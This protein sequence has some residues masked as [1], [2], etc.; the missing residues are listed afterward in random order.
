MVS[1]V[2]R[3]VQRIKELQPYVASLGKFISGVALARDGLA[4]KN[5]ADYQRGLSGILGGAEELRKHFDALKEP[6]EKLRAGSTA[7]RSAALLVQATQIRAALV[8]YE[9]KPSDALIPAQGGDPDKPFPVGFAIAQRWVDVVSQI[10][11]GEWAEA[12]EREKWNEYAIA[13]FAFGPAGIVYV[14][15]KEMGVVPDVGAAIAALDKKLGISE[16]LEKQKEN[17]D[18]FWFGV[19]VAAG[20]TAGIA[21]L[22]GVGYLVRSFRG[23]DA[24]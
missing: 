3:A 12:I 13:V 14:L 21:G 24:G 16:E 5:H 7:A 2:T 18:K 6:L 20:V 23:N 10:K 9:S 8:A 1:P 17:L 15:A 4:K 19:K 11:Q 22:F